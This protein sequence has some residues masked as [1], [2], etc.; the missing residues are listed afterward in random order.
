MDGD[1]GRLRV[2]FEDVATLSSARRNM[3]SATENSQVVSAVEIS[4]GVLLGP[5]DRP[6]VP[7]VHL[8]RFGV[9]PQSSQPGKWRFI[10]DMYVPPRGEEHEGYR[11]VFLVVCSC[12]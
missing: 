5:F 8:N 11:S 6:E 12:G 1:K 10:V 9:I 4:R 2:G 3:Q 7:E